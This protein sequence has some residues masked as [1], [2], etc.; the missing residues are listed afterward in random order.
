MNI[1][2]L[3]SGN[4][5]S[6]LAGAMTR[7]G[8]TVS[9]SA[10]DPQHARDVASQTG[11]QAAASNQEAI[12]GAEVVV[13]AV[14]HQA[15]DAVLDALGTAL[16]GKVLV[17]ATNRLNMQDMASAIDGTSAAEQIQRQVPGARVVKAFDYIFAARLADPLVDGT[18]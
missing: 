11:A 10:S 2:I 13:L 18:P 3:G 12:Q 1:A 14:P 5:G 6:A 8:H 9:I 15:L 16:D 17:D 7:A 4:V